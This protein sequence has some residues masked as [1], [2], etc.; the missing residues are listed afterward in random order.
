[1]TLTGARSHFCAAH[2]LPQHSELHGHSY[3]VWAYTE[4]SLDAELWQRQVAEAC[5][6]LDHKT[7]GEE[8]ATMEK[9][10][11]WMGNQL[12]ADRVVVMRP[13]EGLAVEW[14]NENAS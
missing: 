3:E 9:I 7:L 13:V 4:M 10:A 5:R 12:A 2:S 6:R 8:M 1:M 14:S 11:E